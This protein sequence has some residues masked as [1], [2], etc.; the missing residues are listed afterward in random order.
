MNQNLL[1][2][3]EL[4]WEEQKAFLRKLT[5]FIVSVFLITNFSSFDIGTG[6][7]RYKY[8]ISISLVTPK[9]GDYVVI[10]GHDTKYFSGIEFI[11]KII[12][13][14]GDS[15]IIEDNKIYINQELVGNILTNTKDNKPLHS[16]KAQIIPK[17]YVFVAGEHERSFDSRYEE[18]GLV[19]REAIKAR[20]FA[21]W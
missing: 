15:I 9:K 10:A 17:N 8:F 2:R 20:S 3:I 4:I 6:S 18:F 12:G 13:E 16:I 14:E 21:L 11:K 5:Y 7:L 19:K 1:T